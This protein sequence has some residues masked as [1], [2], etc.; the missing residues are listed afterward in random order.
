MA[1]QLPETDVIDGLKGS[2][3]HHPLKNKPGEKGHPDHQKAEPSDGDDSTN[4]PAAGD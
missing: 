4:S 2:Q 1:K 3:Q